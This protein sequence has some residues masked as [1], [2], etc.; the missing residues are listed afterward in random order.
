MCSD[1]YPFCLHTWETPFKSV[2]GSERIKV[3]KKLHDE[4]CIVQY[5]MTI[6]Q[7]TGNLLL[8]CTIK[9]NI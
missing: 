4:A 9:V 7:F 5:V 1:I 2:Y 3:A 8:S 6:V